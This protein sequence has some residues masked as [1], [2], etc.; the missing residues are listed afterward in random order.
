MNLLNRWINSLTRRNTYQSIEDSTAVGH[1]PG[2]FPDE[3]ADS[4]NTQMVNSSSVKHNMKRLWNLVEYLLIKSF[5]IVFV[6][7]FRVL[8]KLFNVFYSRAM[9]FSGKSKTISLVNPQ[10]TVEEFIA[11]L[12]EDLPPSQTFPQSVS[13]NATEAVLPPFFKSNH[14]QALYMATHRAKFLFVFLTNSAN[15]NSETF[16]RNLISRPDFV[17]LFEDPNVV[18]WGGDVREPEA[19]QFANSLNATELPF[20]GLLCLTRGTFMSPQ[21]PVKTAPKLSL[22]LK[23]QGD[24]A[25]QSSALITERFTQKMK[26]FDHELNLIRAEIRSNFMSQVLIRRQNL[27]YE[28]SLRKDRMKRKQRIEQKRREEYLKWKAKYF[29]QLQ[30]EGSHENKAKIA[31]KFTTGE[32]ETFYFPTNLLLYDLFTFT[33][34]KRKNYINEVECDMTDDE[35]QNKFNDFRLSFDFNL[36]LPLG[37]KIHLSEYLQDDPNVE[38]KDI[39]Y[40]CPKGLLL[41][42]DL[43]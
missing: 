37:R 17:S 2:S 5:I 27:K 23:V 29:L 36:V 14:T 9:C 25:G 32:R 16:L 43:K 39:G 4:R 11:R 35:A 28:T 8:I 15:E 30:R 22:I 33:E 3:E 6:A 31:I 1:I 19:Y 10:D 13:E 12:K 41:V 18:I 7:L 24:L 38:I 26:T 42:E 20:L 34:V 21:G 40:I